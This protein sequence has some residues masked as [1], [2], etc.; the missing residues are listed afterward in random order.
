MKEE[1]TMR[2]IKEAKSK[3]QNEIADLIHKFEKEHDIIVTNLELDKKG[4]QIGVYPNL[5]LESKSIHVEL[6]LGL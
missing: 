1:L 6:D 4:Y 3:L 2:Q 5:H